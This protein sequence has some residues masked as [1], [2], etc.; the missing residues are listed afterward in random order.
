M[1]NQKGGVH[2]CLVFGKPTVVLIKYVS[3]PYLELTAATLFFKNSKMLNRE[4]E[5]D[6][7]YESFWTD[8][9]VMVGF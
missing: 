1:V 4:L 7:N 3:I 5:V 8:S 2:C 9:Q 6:N